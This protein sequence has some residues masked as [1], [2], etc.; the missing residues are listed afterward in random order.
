M[1]NVRLTR[2]KCHSQDGGSGGRMPLPTSNIRLLENRT[3][4]E[5]AL[6]RAAMFE[7]A[8]YARLADRLNNYESRPRQGLVGADNRIP[9]V[10]WRRSSCESTE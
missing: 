10:R 6:E 2:G 1:R 3:E 5:A 7:R 4:L 8:I 9:M